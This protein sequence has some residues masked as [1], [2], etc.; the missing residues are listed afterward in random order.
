MHD[1]DLWSGTNDAKRVA[2]YLIW[3]LSSESVYAGGV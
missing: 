2:G 1:P 3:S